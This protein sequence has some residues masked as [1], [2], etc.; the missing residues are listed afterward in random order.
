MFP[1][2]INRS[3]G[4]SEAKPAS[5]TIFQASPDHLESA[6]RTYVSHL[7]GLGMGAKHIVDKTPHNFLYASLIHRMLPYARIMLRVG[8]RWIAASRIT[9]QLFALNNHQYDYTYDIENLAHYYHEFDSLIRHWRESLPTN[10]FTEVQYED[11]VFD[12]ENQTRRLLSSAIWNGMRRACG[13]MKTRRPL[14]V[15]VPFKSDADLMPTELIGGK[16][17]EKRSIF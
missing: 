4:I 15:P 9:G 6:A 13:F 16:N 17:M 5:K 11:I 1:R 14:T 8:V 10:R 7:N 3:M 12:Q 2:L